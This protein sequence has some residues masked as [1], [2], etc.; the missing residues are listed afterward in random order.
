MVKERQSNIELLRVFSMFFIIVYHVFMSSLALNHPDIPFYKAIQIPMHIGVPL[1]VMI[2]G[3]FGIRFS[4]AGLAKLLSRTYIYRL[5]FIF[6][7]AYLSWHGVGELMKNVCQIGFNH[8]WFLNTYLYLMLMSPLINK[9][10]KD[11]TSHQRIYLFLIL[12]FMNIY[13][14]SVTEGDSMLVEGKNLTHFILLYLIGNTLH[15]YQERVNMLPLFKIML[16]LLVLNTFLVLGFMYVPIIAGKIWKY[17]YPYNSP[18]MLMN[19]ILVF[20]AFSKLSFTSK[21]V[22]LAGGSIFACYLLHCTPFIW[23][24]IILSTITWFDST[25]NNPYLTAPFVLVFAA[26]VMLVIITVDKTLAPLW[27]WFGVKASY[28]DDKWKI[29]EI[30]HP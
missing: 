9:Y 2:S 19:C 22:N 20:M 25:I 8:L 3:Y 14:G 12:G 29:K 17:A 18:I 24:N 13:I 16:A 15:H 7:T 28:Y 27:K 4:L 6:F 23:R 1:F 5:P 10:L 11:I 30:V 26:I 21:M